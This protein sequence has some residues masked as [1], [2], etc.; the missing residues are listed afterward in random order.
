[1]WRAD[2][3]TWDVVEVACPNGLWPAKD[4]DGVSIFDNT[5]F[6]SYEEALTKLTAEAKAYLKL[7]HDA[8]KAAE[9]NWQ[10]ASAGAADA[11]HALSK[12]MLVHKNRAIC[13][14]TS[15]EQVIT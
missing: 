3:T 13:A 1:M 8:L 12:V 11:V 7:S 10:T 14:V 6:P 9:E 2:M 5:H 4:A 15:Q